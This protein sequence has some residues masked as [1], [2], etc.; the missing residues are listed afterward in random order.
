MLSSWAVNETADW[1]ELQAPRG[2]T[3]PSATAGSGLLDARSRSSLFDVRESD[4]AETMSVPKFGLST[5][6]SLDADPE[7]S[8][9]APGSPCEI[10]F[11]G[12]I[13]LRRV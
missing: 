2:L 3:L 11:T 12:F 8:A 13:T 7:P 4:I 5:F 6:T 1:G 9:P 10:L